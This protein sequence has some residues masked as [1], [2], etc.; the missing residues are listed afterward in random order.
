M[1]PHGYLSM[2]YLAIF[3][4]PIFHRMMAKKLVEW[5]EKYATSEEREIASIANKNSGISLLT[6]Q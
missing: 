2:L 5:D 3:I 6:N 1:M 4:P